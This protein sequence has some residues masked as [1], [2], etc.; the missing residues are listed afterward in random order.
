MKEKIEFFTPDKDRLLVSFWI[1]CDGTE[2]LFHVYGE[3][4]TEFYTP[5]S[6]GEF[7]YP[8]MKDLSATVTLD[9]GKEIPYTPEGYTFSGRKYCPDDMICG[10]ICAMI[11]GDSSY[12]PEYVEDGLQEL[13]DVYRKETVP[14]SDTVSV[15]KHILNGISF[16]IYEIALATDQF[17]YYASE[18]EEVIMLSTESMK[19]ISDNYFAGDGLYQSVERI[20]NGEETLLWDDGVTYKEISDSL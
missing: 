1:D 20:K 18:G 8:E 11:Q 7:P 14:I 4:N 17:I 2:K 12:H 13:V 6:G 16:F 3:Y 19:V 5:V 10:C 15:P 9:N